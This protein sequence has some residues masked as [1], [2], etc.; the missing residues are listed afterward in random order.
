MDRFNQL[1]KQISIPGPADLLGAVKDW[2][3]DKGPW[4]AAS[5]VGHVTLL[6]TVLLL[7]GTAK[8]PQPPAD[9]PSFD[10][11]MDTALPEPDLSRF[12]V[13]ETPI[14]PTVL[15]T[16]SLSM[17]EAPKIEQTEQINDNSPVFEAAGGGMANNSKVPNLGGLGGFDIKAIGPGPAVRGA[18]G[19]GAGTGTGTNPGSGGAGTG[20]GGRGHGMRKAMV[21][22]FG[23]TKQTERAVAAAINW[24]AR[25]QNPDGSWSLQQY[26]KLCKDRGCTG[27]GNVSSDA[28]ATAFGLLPFLAAGQ[29]HKTKGPYQK[30]IQAGIAWLVNHQKPDGSLA[31]GSDQ[32]MYTHGLAAIALCEAYG[33]SKDPLLG[34]RAQAAIRF[35]ESAQHPTTGG[36]RY[37][38]GDEGDTS[39]LGW[40]LM[41]LKSAQM[42]YLQVNPKT[43][44]GVRKWLQSVSKGKSGGLFAYEPAQG[45]KRSMTAVGLLCRQYLGSKRD[46]PAMVEGM[47]ALMGGLPDNQSRDL[48]YWYYATQVMHNMTGSEWDTWN[49]TMRRTLIDSQAKEGCAAGSWDPAKP[50]KDAWGE[51]GGRV[52]VTSLAA[53]SLEVYYRYLPL[54]KLDAAS[55]LELTSSS[56]AESKAERKTESKPEKK[57]ESKSEKKTGSKAEK[58][59][60]KKPDKK[61][62]D[63]KME[64]PVEKEPAKKE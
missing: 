10:T 50:T 33:L 13:G 42:A 12:E 34:P 47:A 43:L 1:V 41:A 48:Y 45:D 18:G 56:G 11:K 62:D 2:F 15:D 60:D 31:A 21:G 30:N 63:K 64:K 40:Q 14:D 58:K 49:R 29:T 25:H 46:D 38:P 37:K 57:V 35:I 55:S 27:P 28:A 36:W 26:V 3:W 20:F 9:V 44:D 52:M 22:G 5:V 6:T 17:V 16:E 51:P 19:V 32:V 59:A 8:P 4:Y 61:I 54:Y 53:L 24:I 23:G 7:L 39:V